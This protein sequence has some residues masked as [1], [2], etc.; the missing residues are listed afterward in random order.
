MCDHVCMPMC[1]WRSEDN[2][3]CPPQSL[4]TLF[5]YEVVPEPGA[6]LGAS[7]FLLIL[8]SLCLECGGYRHHSHSGFSHG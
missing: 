2:I 8:P 5:P 4:S 6:R 3:R 7:Q 1:V